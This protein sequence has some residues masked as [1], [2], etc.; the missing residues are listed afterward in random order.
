MCWVRDSL[1]GPA[2]T[3]I[4]IT[5]TAKS[6]RAIIDAPMFAPDTV[7]AIGRNIPAAFQLEWASVVSSKLPPVLLYSHVSAH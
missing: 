5:A 7:F 3:V 1:A 6:N 4:T 2:M